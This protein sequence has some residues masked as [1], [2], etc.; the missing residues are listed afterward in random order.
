MN[1]DGASG[2]LNALLIDAG[3]EL[4]SRETAAKFEAYLSLILRWN[5]RV[6]LTAL[7]TEDAILSRHFVE[8]IGCARSIPRGIGTLLDLGSGAGLP[9]IPVALCR[10]EIRVTLAESKGKK[11]AFLQEAVRVLKIGS[12]VFAGRAETL[13]REFDCVIF[14][15]VDRMAKAV[16]AGARLVGPDGWLAAMA[17]EG[18]LVNLKASAGG[19]FEW[20]EPIR[21]PFAERR[22]LALGRRL[23][24]HS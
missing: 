17:T 14:R 23:G 8:S 22:V 18:E 12:E 6:N 4:L 15:A 19:G 9:G 10:Q 13:E 21:M 7:R 24:S 3:L 11:A 16:A 1:A 2:R 5:A 20:I